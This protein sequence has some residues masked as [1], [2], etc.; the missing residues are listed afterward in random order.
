LRPY[1]A[2]G[3]LVWGFCAPA[4]G[5][6]GENFALR[7][8]V[9][10]DKAA[11][12]AAL[13][14]QSPAESTSCIEYWQE[15]AEVTGTPQS[16]CVPRNEVQQVVLG[17]L[18][19]ETQYAYRVTSAGGASDSKAAADGETNESA[20]NKD[21]VFQ[22]R[23]GSRLERSI[24]FAVM[25]DSHGNQEVL[26]PLLTRTLHDRPNLDFLLQVGDAVDDGSVAGVW[27][28]D[29]I[30][31]ARDFLAA[32]PVHVAMGNHDKGVSPPFQIPAPVNGVESFLSG[33]AFV[34]LANSNQD[35][36]PDG[37]QF[38]DLEQR[39]ASPEARA[40]TWRFV[41]FHHPPFAAGWGSCDG[42][43]GDTDVREILVPLMTRYGVDVVFNGHV[44][45][46]ERGV[47]QGV[48]YVTTGGGGGSLDHACTSWPHIV[49]TSYVHHVLS[50]DVEGMHL[51]VTAR[52]LD[53]TAIDQFELDQGSR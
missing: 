7:T 44:H 28:T 22:F 15:G 8:P 47:W 48:T 10:T 13:L 19:A 17:G 38:H 45:G 26:Q 41:A 42:Y 30:D 23:T 35:F 39:L 20:R 33:N 9:M 14:W 46:Y 24:H 21:K 37:K 51:S 25:G 18:Q 6:A 5:D 4:C 34:V 16:A 36:S 2:A 11:D 12:S 52:G 40:A 31:P 53:G 32:V 1:F 27:Y 3:W 50:V 29:F 43:D 49:V